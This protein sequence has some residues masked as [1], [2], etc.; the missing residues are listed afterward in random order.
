MG[1]SRNTHH[2]RNASPFNRGWY[3]PK[4]AHSQINGQTQQTV[5]LIILERQTRKQS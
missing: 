1:K 5:D 3:T 4:H 2:N